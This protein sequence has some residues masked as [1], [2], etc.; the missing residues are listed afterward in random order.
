[1]GEFSPEQWKQINALLDQD[2]KRY[3][4]PEQRADSVILSSFNIRKLGKVKNKSAGAFRLL[5]RYVQATDLLAIQEIQ[6]DLAALGFLKSLAGDAFGM[7]VSDVTGAIPGRPG[8]VERLG[9]LFRWSTIE[10]TEV[11]SDISYDRSAVQKNLLTRR[12]DFNTA[13]KEREQEIA[14]FERKK[15]QYAIDKERYDNGETDDKPSRPSMPPF[16]LPHFLT[17]IRSPYCCSF[18]VKPLGPAEPYEFLAINA[19]LLYG[20]ASKQKLERQLEFEA[21]LDWIYTR[22]KKLEYTYHDNFIL[23]GDLNLDFDDPEEDRARIENKIKEIDQDFLKSRT[24]ARVNFPFFDA[25]P[26]YG[27]GFPLKSGAPGPFRTTARLK[28][29]Y[30]QIGIFSHDPRLPDHTANRDAGAVEGQYDYGMFNFVRL[31]LDLLYGPQSELNQLSSSER[32]A[33]FA[34]F[35]HDLSD[36]MPIWVRLPKPRPEM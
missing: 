22:A 29:T 15:L 4:F 18:K 10:R 28:D 11:A 19:H 20:D 8:L 36:H 30:D 16:K 26:E 3:G 33:F 34:L 25:H 1:M 2:P 17:F 23:L 14:E 12:E 21:L 35:E 27:T 24:G 5:A 6:D 31:F 32:R 9:F 13:L 7:A